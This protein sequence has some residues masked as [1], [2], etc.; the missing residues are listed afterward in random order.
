MVGALRDANP[1]SVVNLTVHGIGKPPRELDPGEDVAW[2]SVEQFEAVLDAAVGR[3]HVR[4]TFDD[5]NSSDVEIALP[6][7]LRRKL[8]AEFFIAAGLLGEPGRLDSDTVRELR[9]AGMAIGSHGWAHRD[10][11]RLEPAQVKEELVDAH[12]VL[13]E[14]AGEPVSRVSIPFGSYDRHV[15]RRLRQA[16]VSR[17]YT[18]DGGRARSGAWLQARNSLR[19]DLDDGWIRR[20]VQNAPPLPVRARQLAARTVKRLRG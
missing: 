2:V 17:A 1:A 5:G 18:S 8:T 15:L 6:R 12:R 11:R 3:P 14:L 20:V 16:R 10:W 9:K 4:L 19:H 7:L 13:D